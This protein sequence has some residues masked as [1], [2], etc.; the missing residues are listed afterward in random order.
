MQATAVPIKAQLRPATILATLATLAVLV[1]G[2]LALTQR[3]DSSHATLT[4]GPT[5]AGSLV[6]LEV[7][8]ELTV[9]LPA[10]PTT[11]YIWSVISVDQTLLTQIGEA[12]FTPDSGLVGAGGTLTLRFAASAA[13]DTELELGYLRPWEDAEPIDSYRVTVQVR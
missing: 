8:G 9:S 13:G 5:E 10:N 2:G 7:G 6:A 12:E 11:G 1:L 4:L 3:G